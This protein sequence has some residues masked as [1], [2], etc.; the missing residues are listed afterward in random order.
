MLASL[1]WFFALALAAAKLSGWLGR[2]P[3]QRAIAVFVAL[4]MW[5]VALSLLLELY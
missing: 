2:P 5:F 1:S 3:V 4:I